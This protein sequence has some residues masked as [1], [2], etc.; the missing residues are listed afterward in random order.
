[1]LLPL[2]LLKNHHATTSKAFHSIQKDVTDVDTK[3]MQ[4]LETDKEPKHASQL[5]RELSKTL[6]KCTMNLVELGRRRQ[7]EKELATSLQE[8]V[9]NDGELSLVVSLYA[10]M[11]KSRDSDI[12]TLPGKIESQRNVLY[13]LIAQHDSFMQARLAREALRDSKAMKTLSVLTILFLPGAFVATVFSTN[14]FGFESKSQQ[15]R[16][17]FAIVIPL[18]LVLMIGWALWLARTPLGHD[19]ELGREI[20]RAATF[21]ALKE[22][23]ND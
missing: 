11:S 23:K 19:V 4:T 21:A 16:V 5:Y 18:T 6:H 20:R 12:E 8:D 3:L 22:E 15:I 10:N 1:M 9:Q 14:M 7:F 2:Q 13:N 17:Y